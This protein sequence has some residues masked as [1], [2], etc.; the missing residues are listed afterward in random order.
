M[1]FTLY[2]KAAEKGYEAA[3]FHLGNCYARGAG[4]AADE[5]EAY[6]WFK[7]AADQGHAS[8]LYNIGLRFV[9]TLVHGHRAVENVTHSC[10]HSCRLYEGTGVAE[11]KMESIKMFQ[12]AAEVGHVSSMVI[13]KHDS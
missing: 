5:T 1:A 10:V 6:K 11:N 7:K 13:T 2:S 12:K 8:S 4:V 9:R 3:Q